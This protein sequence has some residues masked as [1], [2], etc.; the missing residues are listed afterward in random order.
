M[1]NLSE[2]QQFMQSP[3]F[4]LLSK[5]SQEDMIEQEKKYL[6]LYIKSLA[7]EH[8]KHIEKEHG[9]PIR[10]K[11]SLDISGNVDVQYDESV[12][13]T[14]TQI[15]TLSSVDA[16]L[17]HPLDWS[18]FNQ[19]FTIDTKFHEARIIQ[20]NLRMLMSKDVKVMYFSFCIVER[21]A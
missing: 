4:H 10:I 17:T 2:I 9:E 20:Q 21:Q 5:E 16:I 1:N 3:A 14:S 12:V 18:P 8:F 13:E 6:L 19:G 15:E 7:N 11:M